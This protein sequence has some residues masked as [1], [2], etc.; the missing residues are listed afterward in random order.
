MNRS[1]D[2]KAF[3]APSHDSEAPINSHNN[4]HNDSF[5]YSSLPVLYSFRRCPYAI[6]ARM[7]LYASGVKFQTIEVSLRNKPA[8]LVEL[9]PKATV[10]VLVLPGDEVID[11]SL[12]IMRWALGQSD[13]LGWLE[14]SRARAAM[15]QVDATAGPTA[16]ATLLRAND[17]QFKHWLD[18]YKYPVRYP[19]ESID[20]AHAR[21]QAMQA[22]IWPLASALSEERW[23]G[24]NE[25]GLE[26]VAI[27]PFVRQFSG[28]E[29]DWFAQ[30]VP[31]AVRSWLQHWLDSALFAQVMQKAPC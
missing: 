9:S 26:D 27:F 6:R 2:S 24:G 8:R 5:N 14:R 4:S 22:L 23:L 18:R 11:E 15:L 20:V 7:A 31:D 19:Q 17:T 3:K 28:V 10:P 29:P 12:D 25:P 13:T 16:P 21:H 1:C 30:N